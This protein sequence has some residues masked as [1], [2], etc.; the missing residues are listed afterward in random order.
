[1][2][3]P[4]QGVISVPVRFACTR[5]NRTTYATQYLTVPA[6]STIDDVRAAARAVLDELLSGEL[7]RFADSLPASSGVPTVCGFEILPITAIAR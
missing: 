2:S 4:S 5:G 6:Y 7:T 1:M 3:S